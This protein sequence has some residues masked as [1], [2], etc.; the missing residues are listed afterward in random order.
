VYVHVCVTYVSFISTCVSRVG[1]LS[2]V[3]VCAG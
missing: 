2:L 3:S 1:R